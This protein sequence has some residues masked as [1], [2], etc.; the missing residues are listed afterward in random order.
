MQSYIKKLADFSKIP[1]N[2]IEAVALNPDFNDIDGLRIKTIDIYLNDN[3]LSQYIRWIDSLIF[4][5]SNQKLDVNV[6]SDDCAICLDDIEDNTCAVLIC[7]HFFHYKCIKKWRKKRN[8]CPKCTRKI[9]YR[10]IALPYR[11][12][13]NIDEILR[14]F[15]IIEDAR[16]H[17]NQKIF[18]KKIPSFSYS[19][20]LYQLIK[21]A[22]L[23][24]SNAEE[25]CLLD[26]ISNLGN[27]TI[28]CQD[29]NW[30]EICNILDWKY[31]VIIR[32]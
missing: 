12:C 5:F 32:E 30:G 9:S 11:F 28:I 23:S 2:I 6:K 29:I 3:D 25:H 24:L 22:K 31:R 17:F 21:C 14:L 20:I 19:Y 15:A 4:Y 26:N 1:T 27:D 18:T 16:C 10:H 7:D 13:D 8:A